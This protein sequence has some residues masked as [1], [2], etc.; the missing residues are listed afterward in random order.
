ME[1][2][3]GIDSKYEITDIVGYRFKKKVYRIRALKD[4]GDVKKGDLGGFVSS[5]DNLSQ[6]DNC[7]IY[8]DAA[9]MDNAILEDNSSI[10]NMVIMCHDSIVCHNSK[11]SKSCRIYGSTKI[12]NS[13]ISGKSVLRNTNIIGSTIN[14]VILSYKGRVWIEYSTIRG[15]LLLSE[16]LIFNSKIISDRASIYQDSVIMRSNIKLLNGSDIYSSWVYE[17][18]N[19]YANLKLHNSKIYRSDII[20]D[21]DNMIKIV[22]KRVEMGYITCT[23][24]IISL[25]VDMNMIGFDTF[26]YYPSINCWDSGNIKLIIS[27]H[28]T[29]YDNMNDVIESIGEHIGTSAPAYFVKTLRNFD[30]LAK[31]YFSI[32]ELN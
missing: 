29:Y 16:S 19:I 23:E 4:F 32:S 10:H 5:Y 11:I 20:G 9:V 12:T 25:S 2:N 31:E 13:T 18:S 15:S 6:E 22:N 8:D 21:I 3:N 24:D 26:H 27:T 17:Y 30:K 1:K 14:G 7:W 28:L